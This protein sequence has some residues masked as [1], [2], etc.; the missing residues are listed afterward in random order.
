MKWA[1]LITWILTAGGGSVLLA[2][3]LARGGM[4]LTTRATASGH[5]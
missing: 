3:W 2:I 5:R 1:A 4:G